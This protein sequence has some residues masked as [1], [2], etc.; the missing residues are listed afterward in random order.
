M[1]SQTLEL[2]ED[3]IC[4]SEALVRKDFKLIKWTY[5]KQE[6]LFDLENDP[7]ELVDVINRTPHQEL[8]S[9]MR[10]RLQEWREA[11]K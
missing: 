1:S 2:P 4:P 5:H 11:V 8:L 3:N 7:L 10:E 6:Q 9:E